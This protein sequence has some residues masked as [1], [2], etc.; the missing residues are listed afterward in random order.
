MMHMFRM[1]NKMLAFCPLKWWAGHQQHCSS[2][3]GER[4]LTA[5]VSEG[6]EK[7][8]RLYNPEEHL[9]CQKE[10]TAKVIGDQNCCIPFPAWRTKLW[11][12]G[13]SYG[14]EASPS[15][16]T[17]AIYTLIHPLLM[18]AVTAVWF[19]NALRYMEEA[20]IC[21]CLE[22][23]LNYDT[24]QTTAAQRGIYLFIMIFKGPK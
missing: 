6:R 12:N 8:P 5:L 20:E 21:S 13:S 17:S 2:L 11:S 15:P 24:P 18:A 23:V 10:G 4:F 14:E 9:F 7:S 16:I 22:L 3:K 19:S 1:I